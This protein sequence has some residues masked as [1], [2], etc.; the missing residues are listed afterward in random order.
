MRKILTFFCLCFYDYI[1][2]LINTTHYF[3]LLIINF[4]NIEYGTRPPHV[5]QMRTKS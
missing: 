1:S 3:A 4:D 5:Y 2:D